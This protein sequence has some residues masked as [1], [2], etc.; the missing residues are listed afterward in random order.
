MIF[1]KEIS[2]STA[3]TQV[4]I[5]SEKLHL[6]I[7]IDNQKNCKFTLKN[8]VGYCDL[9][10]IKKWFNLF[11]NL[12]WATTYKSFNISKIKPEIYSLKKNN[13]KLQFIIY[14]GVNQDFIRFLDPKN[15]LKLDKKAGYIK[16][17]FNINKDTFR[18]AFNTENYNIKKAI[19]SNGNGTKLKEKAINEL[20][21]TKINEILKSF[22]VTKYLSVNKLSN[23]EQQSFSLQK[24]INNNLSGTLELTLNDDSRVTITFARPTEGGN[25]MILYEQSALKSRLM[26]GKLKKWNQLKT[27]IH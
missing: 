10:K 24:K 26:L 19:Y 5:N 13:S 21:A 3:W 12:T 4:N 15:I 2:K 7:E 25:N 9:I 27:H 20:D 18:S 1:N 6:K 22:T 23:E 17:G 14:R 11:D 8:E 16:K